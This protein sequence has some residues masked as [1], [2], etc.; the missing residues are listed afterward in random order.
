MSVFAGKHILIII[1]NL[2]APFDR[3]VWQEAMTL[4]E[5]GADVSIICPKMKGFTKSFERIQGIDIYRHYLPEEGSGPLGY[6]REYTVALFFECFLA[7]RIFFKKKFQVIQGCNPP[8]LIFLVALL[9]KP[10]GVKYV[11]DHHD[12]NPELYV[13]KYNKKG[14][15]YSLMIF[16]E[17][18]TFKIADY[19]IA[20][21]Q[22]YKEIAIKRGLMNP[23]KIQIVRS[24]PSLDRLKLQDPILK[25]KNGKSFLV[26]YLG[27]IGP[28]EGID[29]LL[30]AIQILSKKRDDFSVAIIGSGT[31][32]SQLKELTKR[33][34]LENI[35]AFYGRVSDQILLDILNT[36]DI[37]VNPDIPT[38]MNN[39]STMNK[40]MEYMALKKPIIQFDLKEGR[41]SAQDAS[42]Y[43]KDGNVDDF[44]DKIS[45]LMD[46]PKRREKMGLFGFNRVQNELSW[47]FERKKLIQ[48]YSNVLA[49]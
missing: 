22:S 3:R 47:K 46:D 10:F 11:F 20:T 29:L 7:W 41:F 40:I 39:L 23:E 4:N 31:S 48:A 21:N 32:L 42:L 26:G 13:A 18:W 12:I 19:S 8:D 2:P 38:E 30:K 44:A 36:S 43:V 35:V 33:L 37:C 14:I 5:E 24:G 16:L 6:L 15:F 45:Q 27:V 17:R 25:Y 1:E 49:V 28:Q 34:G 9:F